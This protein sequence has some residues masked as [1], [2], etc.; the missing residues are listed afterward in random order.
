MKQEEKLELVR[1]L[2]FLRGKL[3]N[4]SIELLMLGEDPSKVDAAE[5]KLAGHINRLRVN[6]MRSWQGSAANLMTDL[7]QRNERAQRRLREL[8]ESRDRVRAGQEGH[9][10][11]RR[12]RQAGPPDRAR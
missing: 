5:K 3:Q 9:L 2:I 4:L 10:P 12:A 6:L 7:R 1:F 8:K 11:A